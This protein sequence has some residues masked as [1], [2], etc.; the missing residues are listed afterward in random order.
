MI[1]KNI[2]TKKMKE[3]EIK[4][5]M[6]NVIGKSGYSHTDIQK[7][8]LGEKIIIYTSAPGLI[9]GRKGK[10]IKDLTEVLKRKFGLENPQIEVSEIERPYLNP[11]SIARDIVSSF[12]RFGPKRFKFTGYKMLELIMNAGARGA[13]I[14]LS[15]RGIPSTRSKTWRFSSGHL[16]KSG[17]VSENLVSRGYSTA[18]LKS[19]SIGVKVTILTP[20]INFPDEIHIKKDEIKIEANEEEP[21]EESKESPKEEPKEKK[22][23]PSAKELKEKKEEKPKKKVEKKEIK[24]IIKKKE[25]VPSTHELKDKKENGNNKKK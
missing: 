7:T 11:N 12:Q 2:M 13:E 20:D 23:I 4:E 14:V 21:K 17:D 9:V 16:K 5:Y 19:G 3:F 22:K 6:E 1:E 15:G 8:P 24:K 10:S 25:K 18:H